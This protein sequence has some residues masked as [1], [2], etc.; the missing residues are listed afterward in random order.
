MEYTT[1]WSQTS[2]FWLTAA[3]PLPRSKPFSSVRDSNTCVFSYRS[4]DNF[5]QRVNEVHDD[6]RLL[7][8]SVGI[9]LIC[10]LQ[11]IFPEAVGQWGAIYPP[12]HDST[13]KHLSTIHFDGSLLGCGARLFILRS[14]KQ[15][16][17]VL[18]GDLR[19]AIHTLSSWSASGRGNIAYPCLNA[20][21]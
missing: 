8:L 9:T 13:L 16:N 20:S 2:K 21:V 3:Q 17:L 4:Q 19:G 11:V 18:Q 12:V 6:E 7:P 10:E 14:W 1:H 15:H 5:Q